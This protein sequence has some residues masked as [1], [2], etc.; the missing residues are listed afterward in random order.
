MLQFS[1]MFLAP[2]QKPTE[3]LLRGP[4]AADAPE[5]HSKVWSICFCKL[6]YRQ[7]VIKSILLF[8]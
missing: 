8:A 7:L 5:G 3:M 4:S 6:N 2:L 1:V